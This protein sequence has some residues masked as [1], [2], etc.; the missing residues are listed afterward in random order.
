[1]LL[2][3]STGLSGVTQ[4][5]NDTTFTGD[6]IINT[7]LPSIQYFVNT[8]SDPAGT[9]T[10]QP[11]TN[12]KSGF[13]NV[14]P[15]GTGTACG[16]LFWPTSTIANGQQILGIGMAPFSGTRASTWTIG[17]TVYAGS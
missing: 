10:L 1:M 4:S 6:I 2:A 14:A 17:A 11:L 16:F 9:L 12:N 15:S 13:V 3:T 5:G 8:A 7:A